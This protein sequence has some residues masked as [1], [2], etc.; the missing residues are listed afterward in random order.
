MKVSGFTYVRNG[1][2]LDYPFIESIK[3]VLPVVDEMIVVIGDSHDGSRTAVENINDPKIKIIDTIW[4]DATRSG[5][6]IFAEQTNIG[7]DHCSKD[8]DWLFHIQAD[9]VIHE[10]DIAAI[11][12]AMEKYLNDQKVEGFLFN[13]LNFFGDYDHYGP[14]RRFHQHEI[15]I[16][17]NNP[18]IRSYRDSQGFRKF[19]EPANQWQEKGE[20]LWVKKIEATIYHYSYVKNPKKQLLKTLE[21]SKRWHEND[22]WVEEY[23][24]KNKD[25]YDFGRIDYLHLFTATHPT[26]MQQRITQKDWNYVYDPANNDMKPKEKFMKFL[27][28]LT[29]KQ[30]FIY[31]N[32]KLLS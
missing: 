14:S 26:I 7:M 8:A 13:F 9:E 1:L 24:E 23:L 12:N 17:R 5:G 15:R 21:F 2:H 27:Q 22:D 20:K 25:G 31:K 10:N 28:D 19:I 18:K 4:D 29:G 3:S 6:R 30:F 11:K 16:V 32:Y